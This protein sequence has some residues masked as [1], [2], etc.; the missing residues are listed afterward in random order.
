MSSSLRGPRA[1]INPLVDVSGERWEEEFGG[2]EN[3]VC[4]LMA[5]RA[6]SGDLPSSAHGGRG[7]M[8]ECGAPCKRKEEEFSYVSNRL[9]LQ[10]YGIINLSLAAESE[11]KKK[12]SR[13][14]DAKQNIS[15]GET[16]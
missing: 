14:K 9:C 1:T 8:E 16:K 5:S 6:L 15:R 7:G 11:G 10:G 13:H 12:K 4:L 2:C 3:L